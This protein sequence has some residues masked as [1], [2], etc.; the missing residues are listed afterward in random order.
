MIDPSSALGGKTVTAAPRSLSLSCSSD[1]PVVIGHGIK[2]VAHAPA[3]I[4]RGLLPA[5]GAIV[6]PSSEKGQFAQ[7]LGG[8]RAVQGILSLLIVEI[9][10]QFQRSYAEGCIY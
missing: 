3:N 8:Y 6:M 1:L 10:T 9:A 5:M 7:V 4:D 2:R